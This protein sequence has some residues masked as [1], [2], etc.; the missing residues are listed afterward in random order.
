[1]K[2]GV[3]SQNVTAT[4]PP[5]VWLV[6]PERFPIVNLPQPLTTLVGR[7]QDVAAVLSLLKEPETRLLTLTGPGGVGKTRLS[8]EVA[9]RLVDAFTDG[10]IF[11]GLA[12]LMDSHLVL[13][14]I[15]Q[16]IGVRE[17]GEQSLG[18]R[19][20]V[21]LHSRDLLLVLDNCEQVT[22]AAIEIAALLQACPTLTVLATS[23]TP[24]R[25]SGEREFPVLP[26]SLPE[27]TSSPA[28]TDLAKSPAVR[29]FVERAQNVVPTFALETANAADIGAVCRKLDGLPLAIELAAARLKLF[30]LETLLDRLERRLPLL[31]AGPR[32]APLRQQTMRNAIRWSYDLLE[33]DSQALFLQ[34]TVFVGGFSLP[35]AE[36]LAGK[37][38]ALPNVI[39][40]LAGLVDASLLTRQ[41]TTDGEPRFAM[42]ETV[43]E[44][45]LEALEATPDMVTANAAHA[46]YFLSLAEQAEWNL[47]RG[48]IGRWL[49]TLTVEQDNLRAAMDWF[50]TA[51]EA[52]RFPAPGPVSVGLLALPRPLRRGSILARASAGPEHRGVHSFATEGTLWTWPSGGQPGRCGTSGD[53][54]LREPDHRPTRRGSGG[55]G[56]WLA[57]ARFRRY[58]PRP[59]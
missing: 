42:L 30:P 36:V 15:A 28:D 52:D 37:T 41:D 56:L 6:E 23:R 57:R 13:P 51:G 58:A 17:A 55:A 9:Q 29:L 38:F 7:E 34:L 27:A 39:D 19:L 21:A 22:G 11:V 1:M 12:P 48:R 35:A 49:D 5:N 33:P 40:G 3:H 10:V 24:F 20:T 59:V 47:A 44:F 2:L 31:T 43:R 45:G 26:L 53:M 32:D 16:A 54:L 46:M 18:E 25:L 50:E 4:E 14:T 8:I